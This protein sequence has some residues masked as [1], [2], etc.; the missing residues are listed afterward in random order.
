MGTTLN[1]ILKR[2]FDVFFSFTGLIVLS[3]VLLIV[4]LIIKL[5]SIGSVFF[6][7]ERIGINEKPFYIY[8][9]RTMVVDAE[10]TGRQITVKNDER[11]TKSGVF[12]RRYKLDEL[13]QLINVLRGEMS[14]VGPRPEVKKYVELYT[15]EQKEVLRVK[16]GITDYASI[17]YRKENDL[18]KDSENPEDYYINIIMPHKISLN[19]K[20]ISKNN[21]FIDIKIIIVTVLKCF[22]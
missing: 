13:P 14:F 5:T 11:I 18:L 9:F 10:K 6:K 19:K 8:K 22:M 1:R 7:Q 16:P 20:Y 12:L 21:I 4:S 15:L 3:P 17:A 2:I